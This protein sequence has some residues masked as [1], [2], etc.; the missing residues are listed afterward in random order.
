MPEQ[1]FTIKDLEQMVADHEAS[2]A[3]VKTIINELCAKS[4]LPVRYA[5][6]ELEGRAGCVFKIRNDQ[7]HGRPLATC[8]KEL[9]EMRR[10]ADMGPATTNEI[11]DSLVDGAYEIGAKN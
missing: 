8:V 7:F 10:T 6:S 9:L 11:F 2:A 5:A 1:Q 4:G 3:R